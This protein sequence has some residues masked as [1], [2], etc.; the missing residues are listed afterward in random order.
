[1]QRNRMRDLLF[2]IIAIA[3]AG[4]SLAAAHLTLAH[5]SVDQRAL[6]SAQLVPQ[7]RTARLVQAADPQQLLNL[8]IG[9]RLRD[10]AQADSLLAAIYD[11]Q[12]PRYHHYLTPGQFKIGRA[13][14]R[15]RV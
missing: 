12:S 11:P 3:L 15:E 8:S 14:C 1:M 5:A 6:L 10:E 2:M 4:G 13:S 9:L 7:V